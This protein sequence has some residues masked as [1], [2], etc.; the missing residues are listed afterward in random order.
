MAMHLTPDSPASFPQFLAWHGRLSRPNVSDRVCLAF[1]AVRAKLPRAAYLQCRFF[2]DYSFRPGFNDYPGHHLFV[3]FSP[4]VCSSNGS[5]LK[6]GLLLWTRC[7]LVSW[8][9]TTLALQAQTPDGLDL[10][11]CSARNH[12][13]V[14][15]FLIIGPLVALAYRN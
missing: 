6:N 12:L 10:G 15:Q 13:T 7:R 14:L 4:S 1:C 11:L 5:V 3:G 8:F 2:R 9:I